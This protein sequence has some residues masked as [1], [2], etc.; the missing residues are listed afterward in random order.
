MAGNVSNFLNYIKFEKRYSDH[1]QIAYTND[2]SQYEQYL[3][4]T[5]Q[6]HD[7]NSA[8]TVMIRSWVVQLI[9]NKDSASTINRKISCL[10]SYYKFCLKNEWIETNPT[11]RLSRPKMPKRLP[12]SVEANKLNALKTGLKELALTD[13]YPELRDYAMFMTFYTVGIRRNEL[14]QLKW[15]DLDQYK[16]TLKVLGKGN[17]ERIIPVHDE[18]IGL[19]KR[20][21][22]NE[23]KTFGNLSTRYMFLTD[24]GTKMYPNFIYRK[25]SAMLSQVS[26]QSHLSPH[27][28][29]HSFATH[30]LDSGAELN[31]I[32]EMMGHSSLASTQVYTNNSIE[33]LKKIH[34]LS[35]PKS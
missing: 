4:N 25:I 3:Q 15:D 27:S 34:Q 31:A 19:M 22:E 11:S 5:Y 30:L 28:L 26:T 35:H 21:R 20:L 13:T 6:L 32:K 24:S 18:M 33:K 7:L 2:L 14:N 1:T 29:R 17:K 9:E 23:L 10:K 16:K 12:K 8:S